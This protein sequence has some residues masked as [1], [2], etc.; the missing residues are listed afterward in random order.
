MLM[1]RH[2]RPC[3][4]YSG[5]CII[6]STGR[7]NERPLREWWAFLRCMDWNTPANTLPDPHGGK[8]RALRA[9][10]EKLYVGRW[11]AYPLLASERIR[12]WTLIEF[13]HS[14]LV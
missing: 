11:R 12:E 4:L 13:Y 6:G 9:S 7:L 8:L 5:I 10:G 2:E 3:G 1:G 14:D